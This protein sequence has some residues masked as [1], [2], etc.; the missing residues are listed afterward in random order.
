MIHGHRAPPLPGPL[1]TRT[2]N[3]QTRDT[4][5]PEKRIII[6]VMAIVDVG[7]SGRW[8]EIPKSNNQI[9][10]KYGWIIIDITNFTRKTIIYITKHQKLKTDKLQLR[11][12]DLKSIIDY[13]QLNQLSDGHL[14]NMLGQDYVNDCIILRIKKTWL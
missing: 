10:H 11:K 1:N 5:N 12:W 2:Q 9:W 8:I 14:K 13:L 3:S 4:Q 6:W 7:Y